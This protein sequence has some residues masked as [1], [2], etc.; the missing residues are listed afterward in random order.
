MKL[1]IA[2]D[3]IDLEKALT[4][5]QKVESHADL[6]EI[7]S[8]LLFKYGELAIKK[9]REK[10]PQKTLLADAKI[11]DRSKDAVPLLIQAGAD[12]VTIMAGADR[13]SFTPAAPVAHNL[14]K[15]IMLD[16]SDASSPGQSC[17]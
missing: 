10:F 14:G 12:W 16:L 5:A 13:M 8:L 9:F 4:V 11:V 6:F 7:G 1:Q 15:K 3:V 2:F 17:T